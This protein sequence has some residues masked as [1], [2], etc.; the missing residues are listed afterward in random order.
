MRILH[1]IPPALLQG[2]AALWWSGFGRAARPLWPGPVPPADGAQGLA[3]VAPDGSLAG[4]AG[5][6]DAGG[7]FLQ[8][9]PHPLD[10]LFRPAPPTDDLVIDGIITAPAHRRS[11]AGRAMIEAALRQA[12]TRGFPGLRAEVAAR[13]RAAVQFWQALGFTEIGR[14][15][16]GWPWTG[17]VVLMRRDA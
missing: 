8:L 1:P 16:Y 13:N 10:L 6:R 12:R 7:G 4:V 14:G 11:G 3:A 9:A 15:R 2:A 5:L 17:Q